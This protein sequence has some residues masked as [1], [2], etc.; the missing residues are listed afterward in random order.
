M[1]PPRP[2]YPR[3]ICGA[4]QAVSDYHKQVSVVAGQ[5]VEEFRNLF[6]DE[7]TSDSSQT[8]HET[9]EARRTQLVSHLSESGRYYVFKER[10]KYAIVKVVREK[11]LRTTAFDNEEEYQ[12][13]L[14]DL[15]TYIVD[16][17]RI[18]LNKFLEV[19]SSNMDMVNQG[20]PKIEQNFA[21]GTEQ[22]KLFAKEAE[23]VGDHELANRYYQERLARD[24]GDADF[25]YDYGVF[26]TSINDLV[27]AEE[28]FRECLSISRTHIDGLTMCGV[29]C[30]LLEEHQLALTC[31]ETVTVLDPEN[32][33]AWTL[34]GLYYEST[35]NDIGME[36]AYGEAERLAQTKMV[37][38]VQLTPPTSTQTQAQNP[39]TNVENGQPVPPRDQPS[40]SQQQPHPP[41]GTQVTPVETT[42]QKE[43]KHPTGQNAQPAPVPPAAPPAPGKVSKSKFNQI[44]ILRQSKT[45]FLMR[46]ICP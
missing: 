7:L 12:A 21:L 4:D 11:F 25:W 2:L 34:L 31:F 16:E 5:V 14:S 15:Y 38:Q 40:P 37:C 30:T 1:I 3:K 41:T 46:L 44:P 18:A 36:M 10:L 29:V 13:F 45:R 20:P 43:A 35:G 32:I 42:E 39:T 33:T 26:L 19:D 22:L 6:A 23:I 17:M 24:R 9:V 27:K 8:S 28:C